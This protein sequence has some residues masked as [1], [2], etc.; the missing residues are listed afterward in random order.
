[1]KY[2]IALTHYN[3]KWNFL[4]IS[5]CHYTIPPVDLV[6]SLVRG[7]VAVA[8][9]KVG[10]KFYTFDD[11]SRRL[12]EFQQIEQVQLWV[13]D[14]RTVVAAAKRAR[15]KSLNPAL[16]YAE[17]TYSCVFGGRRPSDQTK[18]HNQS[19]NYFKNFRTSAGGCPFKV[20]LSTSNDGQALVVKE[21]CHDHNHEPGKKLHEEPR[22][23]YKNK[24]SNRA[25]VRKPVRYLVN[26]QRT[27]SSSSPTA[28]TTC[29][30]PKTRL[31]PDLSSSFEHL[32]NII[33]TTD[34]Y[35]YLPPSPIS[36]SSLSC[37]GQTGYSSEEEETVDP[38]VDL[39][40]ALEE[41]LGDL[42]SVSSM[43]LEDKFSLSP[44]SART[45][46]L[47][48]RHSD[49]E[50]SLSALPLSVSP[51]T[52]SAVVTSSNPTSSD[53]CAPPPAKKIRGR[54]RK[55]SFTGTPIMDSSD[56]E[57]DFIGFSPVKTEETVKD[58]LSAYDIEQANSMA[59]QLHVFKPGINFV[60]GAKLEVLDSR[61]NKWY[62][63]K[64]VQVD[65]GELDILVHYERWSVRFDEWLKMDSTR[66]RP[67]TLKD[68]SKVI[69]KMDFYEVQFY[70]GYT[71]TL[72]TSQLKKITNPKQYSGIDIKSS[73]KSLKHL[74]STVGSVIT[75]APAATVDDP[76]AT[77]AAPRLRRKSESGTFYSPASIPTL[78][79]PKVEKPEVEENIP[80]VAVSKK[81][82]FNVEILE[83]KR[84][85]KRKPDVEEL[86]RPKKKRKFD[87]MNEEDTPPQSKS[88]WNVQIPMVAKVKKEVPDEVPEVSKSEDFST[89]STSEGMPS[90]LLRNH[91]GVNYLEV[92]IGD[93][94]K[95]ICNRRSH[96][97]W[98]GKWDVY[99]LTPDGRKLRS[100]Q[101]LVKYCNEHV[102][103]IKPGELDFSVKS[104][105]VKR[106]AATN[107][108]IKVEVPQIKQEIVS[109]DEEIGAVKEA[110]EDSKN[111]DVDYDP[112]E[113][114]ELSDNETDNESVNE[115]KKLKTEETPKDTVSSSSESDT[116][117]ESSPEKQNL[118]SV[119]LSQILGD[120]TQKELLNIKSEPP[121]YTSPK[122]VPIASP[123][124]KA[125]VTPRQRYI[126]KEPAILDTEIHSSAESAHKCPSKTCEK[127]FRKENLLQMHM[128]HYHPELLKSRSLQAPNVADL[129]YARTVGDHLDVASQSASSL[130]FHSVDFMVP[131]K[132]TEVPKKSRLS[133]SKKSSDKRSQSKS[134]KENKN[135]VAKN[136]GVDIEELRIKEEVC[137]TQ[138]KIDIPKLE[139]RQRRRTHRERNVTRKEIKRRR[140]R[141]S[142]SMSEDDPVDKSGTR[143]L[144][145]QTSSDTVDH[146]EEETAENW[147]ETQADHQDAIINCGCKSQEE[148]GLNV[149]GRIKYSCDVCLTWQHGSCYNIEN[150]EQVP[151]KYI[152]SL[153]ENPK[154]QRSSMRFRHHQEWLKEGKLPRFSFSTS[155]PNTKLESC[156]R[157]GHELSANVLQLSEIIHSLSLKLNISK[158]ADHPKFVMWHKEWKDSDDVASE[159]NNIR[160]SSEQKVN[161]NLP[162]FTQ[163][164][165]DQDL[166]QSLSQP[167]SQLD[168]Q[169]GF[170]DANFKNG[171]STCN[172]LHSSSTAQDV[173]L[174][175][176]FLGSKNFDVSNISKIDE[177]NN[178]ALP[179]EAS[180][181]KLNLQSNVCEQPY[182][183]N[184]PKT[185]DHS[186]KLSSESKIEVNRE[187]TF[188]VLELESVSKLIE[189]ESPNQEERK[190]EVTPSTSRDVTDVAIASTSKGN[191]F[192]INEVKVEDLERVPSVSNE[193]EG[194]LKSKPLQV[195]TP[196]KETLL[197]SSKLELLCPL[198]SKNEIIE[199]Q[200]V[201]EEKEEIDK[202]SEKPDE[203][204]VKMTEGSHDSLEDADFDLAFR[205]FGGSGES[206]INVGLADLLSSH[207]EIEQLVDVAGSDLP[208]LVQNPIPVA[209]APIIPKNER[210][211]PVNCKLNLLKHVERMQNKVEERFDYIEEEL[212][213]LEAEMGLSSE[214]TLEEEELLM[215]DENLGRD[216]A[217]IQSRGLVQMLLR[218]IDTMKKLSEFGE[219]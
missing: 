182:I 125:F 81:N 3:Q 107:K 212:K 87:E 12:E 14:S 204:S 166:I 36:P 131:D 19:P 140:N 143:Q 68:K 86:F 208:P 133:D 145:K 191:N 148:D 142:E 219:N 30:S 17:L 42:E 130:S 71:K 206:S 186:Q 97:S 43:D 139:P 41:A 162:P 56:D 151:E 98:M 111:F 136:E 155:K 198:M 58:Q 134:S 16:K 13:R 90:K 64:V 172:T 128:K 32:G 9:L 110:T 49:S 47:S 189:N 174:S 20:R 195:S 135:E 82:I 197:D 6:Y 79:V 121:S 192:N 149:T 24:A 45:M 29:L 39:D 7:V 91:L 188:P 37:S 216:D 53:P 57:I 209:P 2:L 50:P 1:M 46:N 124:P 104:A 207:P 21:I 27:S 10:S 177:Q 200:C 129:A 137:E 170:I 217:T 127:S 215:S 28:S 205:A 115:I 113:N 35:S 190:I 99:F 152:C 144:T 196:N 92:E 60:Q 161:E 141:K 163:L 126:K 54:A 156:I 193:N 178:A 181:Q 105:K 85:T 63:C 201:K 8:M 51:S 150:E 171:L 4:A 157:R 100:R 80:D 122:D 15:R 119:K 202:K 38:I 179:V 214:M 25:G 102:T 112:G 187:D 103:S 67:L 106:D 117:L 153:C 75:Q 169:G 147:N 94:W 167:V 168:I 18:T 164:P 76:A 123:A 93:G 175:K 44:L 218:D 96:G 185:S 159:N 154:G 83:E 48:N 109:D 199:D 213:A 26:K 118:P 173:L 62:Q 138:G 194:A 120:S 101:E 74:S 84:K 72:R 183:S 132:T 55:Q 211:E 180:I 77:A 210:I 203:T 59:K 165:V 31:S 95:K 11:L 23:L 108:E 22:R 160:E 5:F 184:L 78:L 73:P 34:Q 158:E 66:I 33:T 65:W 146:Q 116:E 61:D 176:E 69:F 88:K 52:S 114:V 40:V 70:D 89:T